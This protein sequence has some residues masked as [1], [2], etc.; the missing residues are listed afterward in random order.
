MVDGRP[1]PPHRY[2]AKIYAES[3]EAN[4]SQILCGLTSTQTLAIYR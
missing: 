3:S 1:I 4:F 2:Q